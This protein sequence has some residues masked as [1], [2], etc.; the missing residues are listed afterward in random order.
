MNKIVF[1]DILFPMPYRYFIKLAFNGTD[2][3]GWQVQPNARTVQAEIEQ[4]L[5]LILKHTGGITGCG[6]TDAGVHS[7][8]F[9]AHLDVKE[10]IKN[11][12]N[13]AFKLNRFLPPAISIYGV[14]PVKA[15]SHARFSATL[16]EYTYS[17]ITEKDP[18]KFPTSYYYPVLL[19]MDRM[20]A[21]ANQLMQYSD[22]ECFSK[23][24]TE[25]ANFRCCL[26]FAQWERKGHLLVFTIRA[27][28]FLRNMVRSIVGTLLDMGKSQ[29]TAEELN[30]I[31]L[32]K[33]RRNAG[34]SVPAKG[35]MLTDIQYPEDTFVK[36]PE[37]FTLENPEENSGPDPPG[38]HPVSIPGQD[39]ME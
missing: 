29:L 31:L 37:W 20:N 1:L 36:V 3:S 35:L 34:R 9:Y 23:V 28:R 2:Y 15:G 5:L 19:D 32:S 10:P 14:Y 11:P 18:F 38:F 16:R 26:S 13:L 4:A 39:D 6:R 8:L 7:S 27:D 25:V 33:N 30:S 21:G 24:K 12:A 17:I 22:F